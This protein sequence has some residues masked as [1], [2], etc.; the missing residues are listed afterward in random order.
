M[1]QIDLTQFFQAGDLL[2]IQPRAASLWRPYWTNFFCAIPLAGP[3][4]A[5]CYWGVEVY[6][7]GAFLRKKLPFKDWL[8]LASSLVHTAVVRQVERDHLVLF[9]ATATGMSRK[10]VTSQALGRLYRQYVVAR[11]RE[12]Q[13]A[14][15][16]A[17]D[18]ESFHGFYPY[19]KIARFLAPG[20][21]HLDTIELGATRQERQRRTFE[22]FPVQSGS[23][24]N[25][26]R[27]HK[28]FF[29]SYHCAAL[30]LKNRPHDAVQGYRLSR[31][32][33][34]DLFLIVAAQP[35]GWQLFLFEPGWE[36]SLQEERSYR[37]T[38]LSPHPPWGHGPPWPEMR[39][40]RR[41]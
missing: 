37:P 34:A 33:P 26:L 9:D 4:A 3:V 24:W 6:Q 8:V 25:C 12:E 13:V 16:I 27:R 1:G 28:R 29:C 30:I 17:R 14:G 36:G 10:T 2:F 31:L 5:L 35:N 15:Q 20:P 18:S 11:C 38:F 21:L 40:C 39:P 23:R 19:W 7:R 32:S 41:G 22:N